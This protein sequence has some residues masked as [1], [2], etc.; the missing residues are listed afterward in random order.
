V[1]AARRVIVV[2]D[3]TKFD[4]ELLVRFA[5][6]GDIDVLVADRRPEGALADALAENDVE[7]LLP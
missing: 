5:G 1:H 3:A 6:L 2:A 7:V 4:E